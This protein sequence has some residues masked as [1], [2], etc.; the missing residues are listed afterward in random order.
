[1]NKITKPIISTKQTITNLNSVLNITQILPVIVKPVPI[2]KIVDKSTKV[3]NFNLDFEF[4]YL[5]YAEVVNGRCASLGIILGKIS[6]TSTGNDIH[7]QIVNQD[8]IFPLLGILFTISSI[9]LINYQHLVAEVNENIKFSGKFELNYHR[10]NMI[11]WMFNI[12]LIF[13]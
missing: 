6:Y 11:I 5:K 13:Y 2:V 4:D 8:I 1:M 3:I 12:P 9:S 10:W 7:T